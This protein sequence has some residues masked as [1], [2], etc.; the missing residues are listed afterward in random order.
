MS[1]KLFFLV[2]AILWSAISYQNTS[3][4]Q[5]KQQV[6]QTE[7]IQREPFSQISKCEQF[8]EHGSFIF[9]G[10]VKEIRP[11]RERRL[12]RLK[13]AYYQSKKEFKTLK[14]IRFAV[15]KIY[16]EYGKRSVEVKEIMADVMS[17]ATKPALAFEVG[18]N[19]LVYATPRYYGKNDYNLEDHLILYPDTFTQPVSQAQE[20]IYSLE[21]PPRKQTPNEMFGI[22]PQEVIFE[23]GILRG[24]ATRLVQP[25]Y[26]DG[27]KGIGG[28][29]RVQVLVDEN[30][31]VIT[32][33]T[34][35]APNKLFALPAEEAAL[36]STYTPMKI[37]DKPVK[38]ATVI[39]YNFV[40]Q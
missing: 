14:T 9:T 1:Q 12:S 40:A 6:S 25:K 8:P 28:I 3:V 31:N 32:A 33:K 30:G 11:Y 34:I 37:S 13:S 38:M 26:P 5:I 29:V 10:Q 7:T 39:V 36:K 20:R 22:N 19:Y 21:N 23:S 15:N 24:R 27:V 18:E 17:K 35:C 16:G 2:A 4:A